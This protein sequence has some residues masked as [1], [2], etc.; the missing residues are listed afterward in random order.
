MNLR[1]QLK[2]PA[3]LGYIDILIQHVIGNSD[4]FEELYTL[5]FDQDKDIAWR[6]GWACDKI[7]R[8]HPEYFTELKKNK[9][10][11]AIPQ[12]H[13]NGKLRSFLSLMNN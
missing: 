11:D 4:L 6:A 7:S 12:E 10:L 2:N 13:H 9:I 3:S 5:M 8:K 1:E